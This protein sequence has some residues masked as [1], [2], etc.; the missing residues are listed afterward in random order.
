MSPPERLSPQLAAELCGVSRST[1]L[2]WLHEGQIPHTITGGGW[3]RIAV[4]DLVSFMRAHS[5]P[6]PLDIDP[7]PPRILLVDD[8]PSVTRGLRRVLRRRLPVA[9]VHEVHDGF[10]AGLAAL[11]VLPHVMVL[12]L[13]MPGADGVE[14][15]VR[16]RQQPRL[17]GTAVVVLSGHLDD[18]M[19]AELMALGV[20]ACL[21]KPADPDKL[22]EAILPWVPASE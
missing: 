19:E 1:L 9:E 13:R 20:R 5:I 17:R 16:M 12:D 4:R 14:V 6:V 18:G 10:S 21:R 8:E 11:E 22:L 2:R 3:R 7:G 15:C